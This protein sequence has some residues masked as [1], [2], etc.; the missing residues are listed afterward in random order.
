M[1]AF[2]IYAEK[3]CQ[4]KYKEKSGTGGQC[5]NWNVFGDK[6]FFSSFKIIEGRKNC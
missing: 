6:K 4:L 3:K 5:V 2:K 1:A